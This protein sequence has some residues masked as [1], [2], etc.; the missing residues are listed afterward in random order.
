MST[1][2]KNLQITIL[3][4]IHINFVNKFPPKKTKNYPSLNIIQIIIKIKFLRNH[5]IFKINL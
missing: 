4:L 3:I 5:R 2:F 1:I